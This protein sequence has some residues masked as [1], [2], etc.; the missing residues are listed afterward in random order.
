MTLAPTLL[1]KAGLRASNDDGEILC[2]ATV[3]NESMRLPDVLRHHRAL[4]I[5]RFYIVDNGSTDG[6]RDLLAAQE[7][8]NLYASE[9]S[10]A[11]SH[12]GFEWLRPLQDQFANGKWALTIDADEMFVYPHCEQVPLQQFCSYL[13]SRRMGAVFSIMLDM[14]SDRSVQNTDYS[15]GNS[16]LETCSYFDRGPYQVVGSNTY[17]GLELRGGPR[18]R[19]FWNAATPFPSPS[20]SKVSLVKWRPG[21]RYIA[22]QHYMQADAALS[23]VTGALLHFKFLSDFHE[24]ARAEALRGEHFDGAREY[25]LYLQIIER[26]GELKLHCSG[27]MRYENSEQL[28]KIKLMRS[29][30]EYEN[31]VH[32][33]RRALVD[34]D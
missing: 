21:Y 19:V 2:F 24:R 12:F 33:I 8:V 5:R 7:D 3:R 26:S 18:S 32:G 17:P 6:T 28:V 22:A 13:D 34:G 1:H 20:M 27:S 9:G 31:F 14:Y 30:A 10:F 29:S 16:L 15:A 23:D 25:K 11:E 4:G